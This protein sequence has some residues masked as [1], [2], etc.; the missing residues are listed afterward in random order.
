MIEQKVKDSS[1]DIASIIRLCCETCGKRIHLRA[2][3]GSDEPP[4]KAIAYCENC[5][6]Y[7]DRRG[8][9]A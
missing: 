1:C 7:I 9:P 5:K 2:I 8:K 4:K 3:F 6:I